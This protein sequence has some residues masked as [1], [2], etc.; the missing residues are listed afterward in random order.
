MLGSELLQLRLQRGMLQ[1]ELAAILH[2]NPGLISRW[3]TG[4][5]RVPEKYTE[6][7]LQAIRQAPHR[8]IRKGW[9]TRYGIINQNGAPP[10]N[11]RERGCE[12]TRR[13]LMRGV[14]VTDPYLDSRCF[15]RRLEGATATL[16]KIAGAHRTVSWT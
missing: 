4:K 6:L 5:R 2:R 3:E 8:G 7:I 11:H 1:R 10:F 14:S 13:C 15:P 16:C 12:L 9:Q